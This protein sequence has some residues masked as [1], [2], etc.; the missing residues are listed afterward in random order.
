MA[1]H[2]IDEN[3]MKGIANQIRSDLCEDYEYVAAMMPAKVHAVYEKGFIDGGRDQWRDY[4]LQTPNFHFDLPKG[5]TEVPNYMFCK[6]KGVESLYIPDTV[7]KIS[8]DAFFNSTIKIQQIPETVTDIGDG[9]FRYCYN[10]NALVMSPNI[11][12]MG[13]TI[14]K[15]CTNLSEVTFVKTATKSGIPTDWIAENTFQGCSNL[16]TI[17]VTWGEDDPINEYAPWGANNATINYKYWDSI[18]VVF[19][20]PK[21]FEKIPDYLFNDSTMGALLI[22]SVTEIY[23]GDECK[24]IGCYAFAKADA[25]T[26]VHFPEGLT[27]VRDHAFSGCVNL[28]ISELPESVENIEDSAFEKVRVGLKKLP[29]NLKEIG[30]MSFS[31]NS[32]NASNNRNQ[33][34]EIPKGVRFIHSNAFQN[35][36]KLTKLTFLGTPEIIRNNVFA[37]CENLVEINVPWAEATVANAPWGAENAQINY[38]WRKS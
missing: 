38:N 12:N 14:F 35:N 24:E 11:T 7:T 21:G 8:D 31:I 16:K 13:E 17:N 4:C 25:V 18:P 36:R 15:G 1:K 20:F 23:L 6:H 10:I 26:T 2:L 22:P 3:T 5:I 29:K 37:G 34:T 33:F 30:A 28:R 32:G 19:R 27:T 9:V